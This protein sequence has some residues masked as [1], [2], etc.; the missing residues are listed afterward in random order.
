MKL[1]TCTV[2]NEP[3]HLA[4]TIEMQKSDLINFLSN[5][6][7]RYGD[8]LIDFMETYDLLSLQD[9]TVAQLQEYIA[10]HCYNVT[11][12]T[13]EDAAT[14]RIAQQVSTQLDELEPVL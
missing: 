4:Q 8:K 10:L 11:P 2:K 7:N 1:K 13:A 6:S 5:R 12:K 3:N 14:Q 9:A